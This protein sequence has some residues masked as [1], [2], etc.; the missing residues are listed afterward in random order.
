M[1]DFTVEDTG[2]ALSSYLNGIRHP[3]PSIIRLDTRHIKHIYICVM[4]RDLEFRSFIDNN[5]F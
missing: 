4:Y 3:S 1:N 5:T 2:L